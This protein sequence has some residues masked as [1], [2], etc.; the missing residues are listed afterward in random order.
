MK[1]LNILIDN[2]KFPIDCKEKDVLSAAVC[3][4]EKNNIRADKPEIYRK[5]IDARRNKVSFVYSVKLRLL[6][7]RKSAEGVSS[8]RILE[9]SISFS[10]KREPE[11]VLIVGSGPC[12]L[13][14]AYVLARAGF[15]PVIYER[16]GDISE[17]EVAVKR[18]FENGILDLSS[19]VQFGEGGAGTFSDGKLNTRIGSPLERYVLETFV[20]FGAKK[21]ILINAKP[22]IGTDVLKKILVNMRREIEALGGRYIFNSRLSD[23]SVRDGRLCRA[24]FDGRDG[25]EELECSKMI[26]AIGHSSRDTYEMLYKRCIAMSKKP[27]AAGVRIEHS[28]ELI[29][30]IQYGKEYKKL[31]AA[32]YRV[33]Y[34]GDERSC[35]SFC[36][37]PGGVVV[38]ASSEKG[39]FTVNGMSNSDRGGE[40]ANSALVVSVRPEDF[41]GDSPLSGIEFQRK[42]ERKAFELSGG[43]K[44]PVQL[45]QD[46][47]AGRVSSSFGEVKPSFTGETFFADLRECLPEFICK[48]LKEGL[49]S[50]ERRMCGFVSSG[51]VLTGIEMRTSAP[52]RIL[53]DENYQSVNARGLF[54]AG[55]G[56]GYAGGIMSAAIDGMR[57]AGYILSH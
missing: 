22:H 27:F 9:D 1:A 44:A 38:N 11:T 26:L 8:V 7:D 35:Y 50:F 28:Q 55:E 2:L 18:F 52:V 51:S 10:V 32:D 42:Y 41:E 43:Y 48:T 46:F 20:K 36:M 16:G 4:A 49:E 57:V 12:G 34:N 3:Y 24:V 56:A 15:K 5:S 17:R 19:N 54:P 29:N 47:L 39:G 31:P 6:S 30:K 25:V 45:S 33:V 53:R 14:S 40:N 21:D 23:I 37:C 13:F